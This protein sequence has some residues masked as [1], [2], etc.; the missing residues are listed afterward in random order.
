MLSK[1][2]EKLNQK[3][4]PLAVAIAKQGIKPNQ[5]SFLGLLIGFSA[6]FSIIEG[7]LKLGAILILVSGIFDTLDGM[8]AR[9]CN[10]VTKFGGFVDSI[11]D[12]YVEI[13][14]FIALG[15]AKVD[16]LVIALALSGSLMVSY[17]R[18]RA[19]QII[20]KCNVGIAER[21]ER[22]LILAAGI[23]LGYTYEAVVLIAFLSHFTA[24]QRV[25][26]TYKS[27]QEGQNF[28]HCQ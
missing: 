16:W 27:T 23:I 8:V 25:Y 4:S 14:I 9:S 22:M 18:A 5:L 7:Y 19:E 2:K 10:M 11:A 28:K 20:E 17:A 13:A 24:L 3:F 6:A 26:Y 21:G 12:R 1:F 15:H